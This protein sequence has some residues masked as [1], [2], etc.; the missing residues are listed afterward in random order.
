MDVR[1]CCLF[2]LE[3][4][5]DVAKNV[6]MER[7]TQTGSARPYDV[8]DDEVIEMKKLA[9]SDQQS[10]RNMLSKSRAESIA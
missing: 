7:L 9:V 8:L 1:V 6:Q 4:K 3:N 5:A 2:P 10:L